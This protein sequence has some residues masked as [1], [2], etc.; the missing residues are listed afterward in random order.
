MTEPMCGRDNRASNIVQWERA[1]GL[2]R[3]WTRQVPYDDTARRPVSVQ[4]DRTD[5]PGLPSIVVEGAI[6]TPP[7]T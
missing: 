3:G 2:M 4:V 1:R 7:G 6:V 5:L